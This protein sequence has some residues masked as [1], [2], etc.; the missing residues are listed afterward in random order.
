[1]SKKRGTISR[2]RRLLLLLCFLMV[3]V[4]VP[5]TANTKVLAQPLTDTGTNLSAPTGVKAESTSSTAV[6]VSWTQVEGA[7]GY[8]VF[9]SESQDATYVHLGSVSEPSRNCPGLTTGQTYYFKVR[10]YKTVNGSKVYSA[11]SSVVSAVA[12]PSAPTGVKTVVTSTTAVTVSWEAVSGASG[13]DVFR[14]ESKDS[15]Y[16][17]LGSVTTTSRSCPGL[18]TGQTY[19][20][21]VRAYKTVNGS[22][23]YSAFSSVVSAVA[24]PSAPTSVKAEATSSTAVTVSWGAVSGATGYDVFRSESK[25]SGYVHLGSVTTTSRSCPGLTIGQTYYFKVR[26]YKTVNGSKVYSAFSSV[27]SVATK[28]SVPTGVKAVATSSSAITVSW[29][30]VSG[31]TG[32]DVYRS[33]TKDS[34][35]V[36][37]GSVTTTSRNCPGLTTGKTYY[38]KVRAYKT[39]NG[40]KVYSDYCSVVSAVTKPSTPTGVKAVATS[41]TAATVSWGAVSGATGYDVYRSES[42]DSNYVLLGSVTTTS[43]SC[44]GLKSGTAYYFKVRA[45]KTVNGTKVYSDYSSVVSVT[46]KLSTPTS[47]KA[48]TTSTSAITVSWGAVSGATGYDVYRSESKDSNYVLLGSVTTTSRNCPGLKSGTTYYFKVRAYK[49]VNGTKVYSDYSSVVSAT[50]KLPAP[51][52]MNGEATSSSSIMVVWSDVEGATG[53]EVYRSESR[54]SNYVNLG[55][56]ST[57]YRNCPGL[58]QG[59][60][61][62]FKVRAYKTVNGSKVYSDFSPVFSMKT[63]PWVYIGSDIVITERYSYVTDFG[64]VYRFFV[65]KNL[66]GKLM[67]VSTSSKAYDAS[68][69][70]IAADDASYSYLAPY[71]T[72]I[73]YE[74]Y[75]GGNVDTISYFETDCE[76]REV[77]PSLITNG[78]E[79]VATSVETT[80]SGCVVTAKNNGSEAVDFLEI[81]VLFFKDGYVVGTDWNYFTDSDYEIKPGK[82]IYKQFNCYEDFDSVEVYVADGYVWN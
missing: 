18:T 27:V 60:T 45:Y 78:V 21:K 54:D 2:S 51:A 19:Y 55:S 59:K 8:D 82:S 76:T 5:F 36:H 11:F 14:S 10:A 53:Y 72:G 73:F 7:T 63:N 44:P 22:K 39:V 61:Y 9:R 41:P 80:S 28:P 56:V 34:N 32:Y 79:N 70:L 66:S 3:F 25:D 81:R 17:H 38:F 74:Y 23:V 64:V 42:K 47:V 67:N 16:V 29:G 71:A 4:L 12:K 35:Y 49:T 57:S 13:Y 15:N 50:T 37:L 46:T 43:R 31:A 1:M 40:S 30:A 69:N 58:S 62:Y 33:E 20:F 68:G 48:G 52:S 24:K 75:S 6:T 77:R 65:V 26:S